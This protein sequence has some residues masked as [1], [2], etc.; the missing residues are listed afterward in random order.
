MNQQKQKLLAFHGDPTV[1]AKYLD[2]VKAHQLADEI[3]QGFYWENGKGCAVG[4]TIHGGE[5]RRY[6]T[7]LGIPEWLAYLEDGLFEALPNEKAKEFPLRFLEAIPVGADL[8]I[9]YYKF[10]HWLLTDPEHGVLR[11][12]PREAEPEVHDVIVRVA[13]L[14]ERAIAGDMPEEGDWAA[15]RAAAWDAAW[16]AARAAARAAAWD[17]A[18]AA[19]RAAQAEKLLELLAAAPVP[20]AG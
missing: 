6:E 19:A 13:M 10:C 12:M 3:T 7:E 2:R 8:E 16:A 4:C 15:A 1:K 9:V 5:H 20:V 17:A 11:L 14:H 18:W